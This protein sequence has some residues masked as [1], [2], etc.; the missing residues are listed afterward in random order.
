MSG[1]SF[2]AEQTTDACAWAESVSEVAPICTRGCGSVARER[3]RMS[4]LHNVQVDGG[5]AAAQ[6]GRHKAARDE[7]RSPHPTLPIRMLLAA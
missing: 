5:S 7:G 6:G 2:V 3:Q 1:T 4:L